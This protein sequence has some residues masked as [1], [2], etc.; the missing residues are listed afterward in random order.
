MYRIQGKVITKTT[1]R[2]HVYTNF[3]FKHYTLLG[4]KHRTSLEKQFTTNRQ[5]LFLLLFSFSFFFFFFIF[6]FFYF[7]FFYFLAARHAGSWFPDQGSNPRPLQWKR[8]GLTAGPPGNS[9]LLFSWSLSL[10]VHSFITV[11]PYLCFYKIILSPYDP[12]IPLLGI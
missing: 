4:K 5:T 1:F 9:L 11:M 2:Y 12:A 6:Y 7:I 8:R 10:Y 3:I